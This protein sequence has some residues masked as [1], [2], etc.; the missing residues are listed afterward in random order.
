MTSGSK[1]SLGSL[2]Q[3]LSHAYIL[4]FFVSRGAVTMLLPFARHVLEY[5]RSSTRLRWN[6]I[7]CQLV[8][9]SKSY[10]FL[11][12]PAGSVAIA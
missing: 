11:Q 9:T 7:A 2:W 4:E 12:F 10:S 6:L 5:A 3:S 8:R 1:M